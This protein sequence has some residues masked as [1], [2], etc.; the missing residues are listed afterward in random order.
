MKMKM[1]YQM[2]GQKLQR[3]VRGPSIPPAHFVGNV[4]LSPAS[5][6]SIGFAAC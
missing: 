3:P 5:V 1:Y 2:L 4:I 6:L